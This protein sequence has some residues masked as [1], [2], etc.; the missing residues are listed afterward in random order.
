MRK[1]YQC[2][3]KIVG[4]SDKK[5][6]DRYCRSAYHN[7]HAK[8][9]LRVV[10]KINVL[11]KRNRSILKKLQDRGQSKVRKETLSQ[12]GFLFGYFTRFTVDPEKR[13]RYYCYEICYFEEEE[14]IYRIEKE[15]TLRTA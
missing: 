3:K 14:G 8:S 1:C 15:N 5:F 6:C 9:D 4:R 13:Q 2:K 10:R 11:L 12:Y 7:E